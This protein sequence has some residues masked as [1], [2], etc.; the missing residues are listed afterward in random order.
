MRKITKIVFIF[1]LLFNLVGCIEGNYLRDT[2]K[3]S[4]VEIKLDDAI[5]IA[6]KEE[7]IILFTQST[8]KD[9]INL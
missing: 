7:S 1:I 9:C 8:C 5:T 6:E 3:G 4:I 2:S